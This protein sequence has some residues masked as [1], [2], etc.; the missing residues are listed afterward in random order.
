VSSRPSR[1]TSAARHREERAIFR[2]VFLFN[3]T[4]EGET[5]VSSFRVAL[6]E[7]RT[8]TGREEESGVHKG[9][10]GERIP[11]T[12]WS[13]ALVYLILL[14][15][16]GSTLRPQGRRASSNDKKRR[17]PTEQPVARALRYFANP[18]MTPRQRGAL[19]AL[20]NSFAHNFGL[21]NRGRDRQHRFWLVN[22]EGEPL[23]KFPA[24][25]WNGKYGSASL[26]GPTIVNLRAL[27]DLVEDV[28]VQVER[29]AQAKELRLASGVTV[30]ELGTAYGFRIWE[31]SGSPPTP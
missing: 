26:G 13:G 22:D 16:I 11:P 24:R 5:F 27:G 30:D 2:F 28:V 15:L 18:V 7:A 23:I 19:V 1:S 14:E 4:P 25:R 29:A 8:L 9:S 3:P 20:R 31:P 6:R 17:K 21:I 12:D 10:V